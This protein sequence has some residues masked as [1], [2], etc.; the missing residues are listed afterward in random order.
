MHILFFTKKGCPNCE[1]I[2][3]SFFNNSKKH[4][5][6]NELEV[7]VFEYENKKDRTAFKFHKVTSTIPAVKVI[8]DKEVVQ[9]FEGS[10]NPLEL[11]AFLLNQITY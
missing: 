6:L 11:E 5:K 7:R 9:Q 2:K 10:I 1:A 8:V 3:S 4:P